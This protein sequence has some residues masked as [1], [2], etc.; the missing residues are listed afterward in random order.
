MLPPP[1]CWTIFSTR[2]ARSRTHK[3]FVIFSLSAKPAILTGFVFFHFMLFYRVL[4]PVKVRNLSLFIISNCF[5]MRRSSVRVRLPAPKKQVERLAFLYLCPQNISSFFDQLEKTYFRSS[6]LH[7]I[8]HKYEVVLRTNG[9][10]RQMCYVIIK[11]ILGVI[12]YG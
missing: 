4:F 10:K 1:R 3:F 5:V 8:G 6:E 7:C 12:C 11:Y 2:F 9:L